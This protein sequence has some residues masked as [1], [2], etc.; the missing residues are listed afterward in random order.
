MVTNSRLEPAPDVTV[1]AISPTR[2][3]YYATSGPDGR[4]KI[5]AIP[6][7]DFRLYAWEAIALYTW[8]DPE[9]M[10]R[11]YTRGVDVHLDDGG[12]ATMNLTS[13]PPPARN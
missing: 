9:V 10:R 4:F 2:G 3:S 8:Q 5:T 13:I 12:N 6:P 7:G 1:V 11:D